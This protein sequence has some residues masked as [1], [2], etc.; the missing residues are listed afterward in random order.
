MKILV[1]SCVLLVSCAT[2]SIEGLSKDQIA[3]REVERAKWGEF[4]RNVLT[5]GLSAG[6][7]FFEASRGDRELP[8]GK[9]FRK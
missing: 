2:G 7:S 1:L 9:A 6:L 8:S 5:L 4:G 3:A